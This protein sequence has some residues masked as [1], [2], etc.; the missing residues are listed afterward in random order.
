MQ[1]FH[2]NHVRPSNEGECAICQQEHMNQVGVYSSFAAN[3][4]DF[5][6]LFKAE[7]KVEIQ[8]GDLLIVWQRVSYYTVDYS[9]SHKQPI[10]TLPFKG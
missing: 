1:H 7:T 9:D 2:L 4:E 5:I 6:A 3:E 10:S 8:P